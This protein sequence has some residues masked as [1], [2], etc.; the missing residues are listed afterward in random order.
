MRDIKQD[1]IDALAPIVECKIHN[2]NRSDKTT[3]TRVINPRSCDLTALHLAYHQLLRAEAVHYLPA[4]EDR[5]GTNI[6]T[7]A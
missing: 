6:D 7:E 4:L 2:P 5:A 1:L 3:T